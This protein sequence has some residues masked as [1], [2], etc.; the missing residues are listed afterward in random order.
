MTLDRIMIC[1]FGDPIAGIARLRA[2]SAR[3]FVFGDCEPVDL[4][5][6]I[7][8]SRRLFLPIPLEMAQRKWPWRRPSRTIWRS[9]QAPGAVE[10]RCSDGRRDG[11][12]FQAL[13]SSAFM[14]LTMVENEGRHHRPVA[15]ERHLV[16]AP[17]RP[18]AEDEDL[19]PTL[20]TQ[21]K[22]FVPVQRRKQA[23]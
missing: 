19:A 16:I 2:P 4:P 22:Q 17:G 8:S 23:R 1:M 15:V 18:V 14:S 9:G 7:T 10:D 6:S 12:F 20:A 3:Q 13:C 11:E 21:I 5:A